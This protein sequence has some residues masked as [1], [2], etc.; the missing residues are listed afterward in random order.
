MEVNALNAVNKKGVV[1][2]ISLPSSHLASEA[3][4]KGKNMQLWILHVLALHSF[5]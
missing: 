5:D 3:E 1:E 2:D 4:V